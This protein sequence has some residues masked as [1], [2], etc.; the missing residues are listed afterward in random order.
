MRR[1]FLIGLILSTMILSSTIVIAA[2]KEIPPG[3]LKE[4]IPPGQYKK[5]FEFPSQ[6]DFVNWIHQSIW[7]R[8][9]ERNELRILN[10]KENLVNPIG[11]LKLINSYL[12]GLEEESLE[13]EP[14]EEPEEDLESEEEPEEEPEPREEP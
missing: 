7:E 12:D 3:Q 6:I 14:E 10:G 4:K 13:L 5:T 11:L 9:Q 1:K 2:P 8:M